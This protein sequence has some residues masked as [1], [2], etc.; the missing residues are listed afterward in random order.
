MAAEAVYKIKEFEDKGKEIVKNANE[1]AKRILASS[2]EDCEQERDAMLQNMQWQRTT[3]IQAAVDKAN[4]ACEE[5][6]SQGAA[7]REALLTPASDKLESAIKLV[8][9][10]I[11]SV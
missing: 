1:E 11:V 4:K 5:I 10:R 3:M 8:M 6:I 2:T 7:E 9:E